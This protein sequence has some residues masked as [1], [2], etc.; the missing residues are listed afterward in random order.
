MTPLR[1]LLLAAGTGCATA[2][3]ADAPLA[4]PPPELETF[5]AA[6]EGDAVCEA[7]QNAPVPVYVREPGDIR[8]FPTK[9]CAPVFPKL[10]KNAGYE[11][12]CMVTFSIAADGAAVTEGVACPEFASYDGTKSAWDEFAHAAFTAL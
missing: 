6:Y 12:R 8:P 11:T 3:P 9:F 1:F 10:L 2:D 4:G 7:P 5:L